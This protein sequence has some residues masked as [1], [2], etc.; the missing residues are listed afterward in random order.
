V[1]AVL[2]LLVPIGTVAALGGTIP[3]S[4]LPILIASAAAFLLSGA[5]IGTGS[6]RCLDAALVALTAVVMIQLLPLPA[7]I[8]SVLSP[9]RETLDAALHL[10]DTDRSIG[11]T[12]D[13][14]LTRA[15]LATLLSALLI[16][17]SAREVFRQS[18][19]RWA[20]PVIGATGF[21][22]TLVASIQRA[23]STELFGG[24]VNRNHLAT[25][26]LMAAA[27]AAGYL[28]AQTRSHTLH[29]DSLRLKIRDWLASGS[30]LLMAGA[31]LIM[32]VGIVATLSRAAVLGLA[33][34]SIVGAQLAP[35]EHGKRLM[36]L[37]AAGIAI[38]VA[39]AIWSYRG[40]LASKFEASASVGR[41]EIWRQTMPVVTDFWMTGTGL[42]TY[43]STML[44]YQSSVR[45]VH[46]N[47][48][49]NDYLQVAAE[50][51]VL[52]VMPLVVAG[53]AGVRLARERIRRE[54]RPVVWLRIGAAGGLTAVAVQELFET[55]LRMPANALLAAVLAAIVLHETESVNL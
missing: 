47:Q 48:A 21:A 15:A 3:S 45:D 23:T 16:F 52:L 39:V 5:R 1:A 20:A 8:V 12:V 33:A 25:W 9:R 28:I 55:G 24:F 37:P 44:Q 11:L 18:G 14:L 42:G 29:H 38:L 40:E 2:V 49:H 7:S 19:V 41:L 43:G 51:G 53:M 34:A 46:F 50:G 10:R 32:V 26:L 27:V 17:W 36:R 35:R 4:T 30:G 13:P 31:I 22:V 54:L 6:A